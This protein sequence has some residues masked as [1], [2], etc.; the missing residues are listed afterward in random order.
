MSIRNEWINRIRHLGRRSGFEGEI[1]DEIRFHLETRVSE[2]ESAGLSRTDA[3]AQARREFGSIALI[4]EESRAAWQFR[5]LQD[6]ASDLLYAL[7]ACRR[8]PAFTLTAVLSL[9]LGIGGVSAIYTAVDVVIWK[10]LPV[11]DPDRLVHFSIS[12]DKGE[13]E[14]DLPAAFV[15][16]LQA[17]NVFAGLAVTSAD[18]LSF[19]YDGRAERIIGEVVSPGYFGVL[20]VQPFLGQDFTP[21]VQKGH[22]AAEVV[23]SYNFW[24]R[25]FGGDPAVIGRTIHLNTYPFAVVGVSP[26]S[27]FGM[28]RGTA[29]EL[30]IPLLPE[31]Q[32][33]AQIRQISGSPERWLDL[34]A[35]LKP[36]VATAQTEAAADAQF[37]QFLRAT[38]FPRFQNAGMRHLHLS[39]GGKGFDEYVHSFRTPLYVLFVLVAFVLLIACFNIANMLLARGAARAREFAIRTSIGAGRFRLIRQLLA[40]SMLLSLIGGALGLGVAYWAAPVLF[41]FLPQGHI[42]IAI[43][44]RP[45]RRALL[46]TFALSLVTG[47]LFGLAPALQATRG[48][49][50]ATIKTDSSGSAGDGRAAGFRRLLV[51]AQVAL[52]LMLLIAAGVFVRTLSN[53]RPADYRNPE[54]ILLFTMKPQQE[55]Y[56]PERKNLLAAELIRRVSALPGVQSAALAESGPLSSR[57]D[58]RSIQAPGRNAIRTDS[59]AVSPGFFDTV[60]IP[61][62][63]GRDFNAG[64]KVSSPLV[65]VVNQSLARAL[66]PNQNP[67]GETVRMPI[68]TFEIVGVAADTHYYDLHKAPGR[69]L[70]LS[71]AQQYPYMPTLHV[72]TSRS[73]T[74]DMIAAVR[75]EF[76][77]LDKGFPVFNIRTMAARIEDSLASERMVANLSGAFGMLALA[78]AAIGL[79]GILAYA[80]SRR[81]REIGI[82]MALGASSGSVLWM[83]AREA[84][85]LVSAGSVAGTALAIIVFRVLARYLAGT[86]TMDPGIAAACTIV[87]ILAGAGA[88]AIPAIRGCRVDPIAALRHE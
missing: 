84:L 65:A 34:M 48:S 80:V 56:T 51:I 76:D 49:L 81:T 6:L 13:P 25:R 63:A 11:A 47:L 22:W 46:F 35:R 8:S 79:Y 28:V 73:D 27:F 17:S 87:M 58:S 16:Q 43:D 72:K 24:Q 41:H 19:S 74:A 33:I 5:W 69:F 29:S 70:W 30:R 10:P 26:P 20:G 77:A 45:D 64:D 1:E 88:A 82:R 32:D 78:L 31:G 50:A 7:R 55:I 57:P 39:A 71:M 83:I 54:R 18:G 21:D 44:M 67:I 75:H 59:D 38:P 37:Q 61:L 12:M 3:T 86:S 85:V 9:A 14:T 36:G 66:L 60:G 40:E 4:Q 2:L 62:F 23:L 53:L 42:N 68:G 15:S 52:S